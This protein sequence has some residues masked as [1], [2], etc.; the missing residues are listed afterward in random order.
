MTTRFQNGILFTDQYQ[1]TMSQVYYNLGLHE[2]PALFDHFFRAY[3]N[4]GA[5]AAGYG[6]AAGLEP[7]LDWMDTARF[8]EGRVQSSQ[9]V[10]LADARRLRGR[11]QLAETD[12]DAFSRSRRIQLRC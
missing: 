5:H 6:V 4:Y 2:R 7:L 8:G 9:M 3:P 12:S 11:P 1:L 10:A